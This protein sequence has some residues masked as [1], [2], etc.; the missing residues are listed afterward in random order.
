[1]LS[2]PCQIRFGAVNTLFTLEEAVPAPPVLDG[3][4]G[5]DL[6][7]IRAMGDIRSA[8]LHEF[9]KVIV[10]QKQVAEE[11]LIAIAAG[12]HCLMIGLP[13]LAKTPASTLARSRFAFQKS[14]VHTGLDALGH[15][16]NGSPRY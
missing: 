6:E 12:G 3:V 13:G 4:S 11:L 2:P 9:S 14:S 15:H 1:M 16:R 7:Q 5:I 10:G 8:I